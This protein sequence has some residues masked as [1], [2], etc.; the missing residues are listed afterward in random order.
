MVNLVVRVQAAAEVAARWDQLIRDACRRLGRRLGIE[1]Q[2]VLSRKE[3]GE[4]AV[5][6]QALVESLV[7]MGV[8]DGGLR[9]PNAVG[10]VT[11]S[12]DLR[13]RQVSASVDIDA[14]SEGRPQTRINWLVR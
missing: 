12:A 4:P 6:A 11:V 8:L 13:A 2:P 14:P 9:I 10:P 5:R 1:V 3:L 7:R